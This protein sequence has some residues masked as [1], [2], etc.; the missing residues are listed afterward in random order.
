MAGTITNAL[1]VG[2]KIPAS[3]LESAKVKLAGPDAVGAAPANV[4]NLPEAAERIIDVRSTVTAS[5][6]AGAILAP[7]EG[8][9][10]ELIQNGTQLRNPS[11]VDF[12]AE[13]WLIEYERRADQGGQSSVTP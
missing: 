12:S 8:T 9:H 1:D 5:G 3:A 10:Y 7:I 2:R 13:T 4:I 11:A 6:A